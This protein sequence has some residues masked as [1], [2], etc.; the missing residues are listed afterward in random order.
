MEVLKM[1]VRR[2]G[3]NWQYRFMIGGVN[4][5]GVCEGCENEAAAKEYAK[6]MKREAKETAIRTNPKTA[7]PAAIIAERDYRILQN[8]PQIEIE[9]A[10]LYFRDRMK[11]RKTSAEQIK[12]NENYFNDFVA[13]VK[14]NFPKIQF[15]KEINENI[16]IAY[17]QYIKE[18]GAFNTEII[19]NW[20]NGKSVV[21]QHKNKKISATTIKNRIKAIRMIFNI[22]QN[23]IG[24]IVNPFENLTIEKN[25]TSREI[26]S[27]DEIN[28]ILQNAP[29]NLKTLFFIGFY[30]GMAL[31]DIATL[32]WIEVDFRR[33]FIEK[34]R[35]KTGANIKVP[36]L[37]PLRKHLAELPHNSEYVSSELFA[38]YK[39]PYK[40]NTLVKTFLESIGI[41]TTTE[42]G[43][44]RN[45]SVKG[46]HAMR[47]TFAYIAAKNGIPIN[48]LQAA[49]GHLTPSM[50]EHYAKH[51]TERDL[52]NAFAKFDKENTA[53]SPLRAPIEKLLD[54]IPV[55]N[56]ADLYK[57]IS[58]FKKGLK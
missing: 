11:S 55:E 21:Y 56:Y 34:I 50:S 36:I 37:P 33:G 39:Q 46:L 54:E 15:L 23:E 22:L 13:F 18:N 31:E 47:H 28:L 44:G 25:P 3:K 10:V 52:Q 57:I 41:K 30:S 8:V 38:L 40:L 16:A 12:R 9:K 26:F 14:S 42:N 58:D 19:S 6:R 49:L 20:K 53:V 24:F 2:N 51:S 32:K 45:Q 5:C 35:C 4:Y 7:T 27:E 17:F 43:N 48:L 1:N 29:S